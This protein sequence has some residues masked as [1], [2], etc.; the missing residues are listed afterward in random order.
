[1]THKNGNQEKL[2][3]KAEV[4][5]VALTP[6]EL[7]VITGGYAKYPPPGPDFGKI[8]AHYITILEDLRIICGFAPL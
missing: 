5:N 2:N 3:K 7:E 4:I 6:S 1:M 8:S